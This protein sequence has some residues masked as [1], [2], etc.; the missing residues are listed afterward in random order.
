VNI[1]A[2]LCAKTHKIFIID[3]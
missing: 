3:N 1:E 2:L